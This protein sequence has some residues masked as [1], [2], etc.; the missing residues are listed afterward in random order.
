MWLYKSFWT[1]LSSLYYTSIK[2]S[3]IFGFSLSRE[4]CRVPA[5]GSRIHGNTDVQPHWNSIFW[6][7]AKQVKSCIILI[8]WRFIIYSKDPRQIQKLHFLKFVMTSMLTNKFSW[9]HD[10]TMFVRK[11]ACKFRKCIFSLRLFIICFSGWTFEHDNVIFYSFFSWID[12]MCLFKV[13][14]VE[15]L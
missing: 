13:C 2:R 15:R 9:K 12:A 10:L 4:D 7:Q 5:E 11:W 8:R 14:F 1:I 6:N 3:S